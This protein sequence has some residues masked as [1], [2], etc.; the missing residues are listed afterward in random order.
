MKS[1]VELIALKRNGGQLEAADIEHLLDA[2][3]RG[4]IPDY[5]MSALLMAIYYQGMVPEELGP[6]TQAMLHS[7]EV[8]DLSSLAMPK[9][10]KHSTGGV[11]D[12]I[13]LPLAPVVAACGAAVPMISGRGLGHTGGTLDKLESIPGFSTQLSEEQFIQQV[14]NLGVALIGQT[15]QICPADKK[16]YA[17][18]D[19]TA[20]VESI[21]LI[22]SSIMSKKL[23]EG[24][25]SLVLDVKIGS[26]AFMK[27]IEDGRVLAETMVGIGSNMGKKVVALLT[28]MS[29]PLGVMIGNAMEVKESIEILQG[30]G[31]KDVRALTIALAEEMLTM[32]GLDP[33]QAE[34]SLDD[35]SALK[36]FAQIIE[37][38]GGDP[39]VC[40]DPNTL[41][42]APNKV[43]YP[44]PSSGYVSAMETT[45]IG[46]ASVAL[47]AG[48]A[49]VDDIINPAVGLEMAT[50][51]GDR[52]E[53]GDPLLW[54]HHADRG[55]DAARRHLD[56]AFSIADE[57]PDCLP[58][59]LDRID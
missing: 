41:A 48:R 43:P 9:V 16:L 53:A 51:I 57:A 23:A 47:G 50:R 24:I 33:K 13:S 10:D 6:W 18:R 59:L 28:D 8:I 1:M 30:G 31:P 19:V 14:G 21:P 17:L 35:G 22:S 15:G 45:R 58:L 38:Q 56:L 29:Q 44:A 11:G 12:K 55:V 2:Y 20:T 27:T 25:D 37:A 3:T 32:S 46:M 42:S 40:D 39:R 7:G 52:V 49:R 36:V 34:R 5:Q 26:G 54:I 4:D